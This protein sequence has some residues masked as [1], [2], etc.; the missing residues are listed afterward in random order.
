MEHKGTGQVKRNTKTKGVTLSKICF[1]VVCHLSMAPITELDTTLELDNTSDVSLGSPAEKCTLSATIKTST[2]KR[3][4]T[5]A[6]SFYIGVR[7]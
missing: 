4:C 7:I 5:Y 6:C 3:K 1:I 2:Q